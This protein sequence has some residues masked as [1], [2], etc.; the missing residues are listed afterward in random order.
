MKLS[1]LHLMASALLCFGLTA[2]A[3]YANPITVVNGDFS[4]LPD[5]GLSN[6]D[7]VKGNFSSGTQ[8]PGWVTGSGAGEYAPLDFAFTGANGNNVIAYSN[9][10]MITQTVGSTVVVGDTYTLTVELGY[11]L[12]VDFDGSADLLIDGN[13]YAATGTTPTRGGFSTFT[14]TYTGIAADAGQAITIELNSSGVQG[15]YDNV[16]LTDVSPQG[17]LSAVPEPSA[18][19]YLGTG[20][21]SL[22][23][24]ARRRFTK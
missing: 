17:N 8:I 20:V 6:I 18:L 19:L 1:G 10:G 11:R 21:L 13:H 12:D 15:N 16:A 23:G 5:G 22:G 4:Q 9:S 3:A 14:A 2:G 7:L 24:L